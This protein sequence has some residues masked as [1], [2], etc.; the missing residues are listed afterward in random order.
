VARARD[1]EN[2]SR[3]GVQDEEYR[4]VDPG[5]PIDAEATVMAAPGGA[6]Q[7]KVA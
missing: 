5:D 7:K 1:R 4:T 2:D 3:G 6:P